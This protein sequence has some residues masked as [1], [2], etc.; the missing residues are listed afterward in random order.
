MQHTNAPSSWAKLPAEMKYAI[1]EHLESYDTRKFSKL[2]HETYI[3]AVPSLYKDVYLRGSRSLRSFLD[4]VP[5]EHCA[6]V[7]TLNV[8]FSMDGLFSPLRAT[9]ALADLLDR[10]PRL[11]ELIL[12]IPG[13][14]TPKI[15]PCFARLH[16]LR[17]LC[18]SNCGRDENTPLSERLVVSIAATIPCLTHLELDRICR[19]AM[20]A[21]EL[22]GAYPFIPVLMG[23]DAVPAHPVLGNSLSLPA[24]LRLPSLRVLRI[25]GTHLGD[26]RWG[27]TP[28]QCRLAVLE[29]GTGSCCYESPDVN[30]AC[31]ERILGAAAHS[32]EE[33]YLGC[34]LA[35]PLHLKNL[36]TLHVS[37]VLPVEH[38]AESLAA[39]AH[40]PV[41]ALTLTRHED[42]LPEEYAALEEFVHL[43]EEHQNESFYAELKGVSLRTVA[44]LFEV[45]PPASP[46][47]DFDVKQASPGAVSA[48]QHLQRCLEQ[49]PDVDIVDHCDTT[50]ATALA[51]PKPVDKLGEEMLTVD[52]MHW[53]SSDWLRSPAL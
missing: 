28:V 15:I 24:L 41:S 32:V 18:V 21:P 50:S 30:R 1:A 4:A 9:T 5:E 37:P 2:S 38:L 51:S 8:D 3:L 14:L 16:S 52:E 47:F 27:S 44:D 48:L 13:S 20:H 34:P 17:K 25:R 39:L 12:S 22:V 42:D 40:S 29:L 43:C 53:M 23:D 31:A 19:S 36:R 49:T 11:E 46:K 10:C 7:R 26:E 33:L 45:S 6:H 35:R